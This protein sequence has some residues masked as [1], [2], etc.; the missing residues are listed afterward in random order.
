ML[1]DYDL[2]DNN[3]C[4]VKSFRDLG[5]ANDYAARLKD[6][7]LVEY[8]KNGIDESESDIME[9]EHFQ[10][11]LVENG[12]DNVAFISVIKSGFED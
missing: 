6:E 1:A 10:Y 5:D 11:H 3:E 7:F 12:G 8:V 4:E 9:I 2:F